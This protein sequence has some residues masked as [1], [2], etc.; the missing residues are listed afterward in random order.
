MNSAKLSRRMRRLALVAGVTLAAMALSSCVTIPTGGPVITGREVSEQELGPGSEVIP[1]GPVAGADQET[2][3]SGFI[4]AHSGSGN[5][6]A[7]R[8]FLSNP[9]AEEWE[10]RESVLIRTGNTDIERLGETAMAYNIV[11]SAIVDRD[12]LYTS[13]P[14]APQTLAYEFVQEAGEWRISAAPDGIVLSSGTF[15]KLF[16]GHTLYFLDPARQFLVPDLRWFPGG[17]AATRVVTALLNGPPAWLEGAVGTAFPDGTQLS[18]PR[19]VA[20]EDDV[21]MVDLTEEALAAN[22]GQRQLMR[23]QLEASLGKVPSISSVELSVGGTPL[24][25]TP[26]GRTGPQ[27][28]PQVDSRML[29]LR[30]GEFGYLAN[31]RITA[32][33]GLSEK[34]IATNPTEVTLD[35]SGTVAATLGAGGASLVRA[36]ADEPTL[37]DSRPGLI[38]PTLDGYGYIWTV[39]RSAP[40]SILVTDREGK[41]SAVQTTLPSDAEIVSL[42]VSRDGARIAALL[43]TNAGTRL[44]VA[45]II[46]DQN[47]GF[48]PISLGSEPRVDLIVDGG[49]AIDA[50]WVDELSVAVLS[51]ISGAAEVTSFEVGGKRTDLGNPGAAVAIVGG[52]GENGLRVLGADGVVSVRRGSGWQSGTAVSLISTQR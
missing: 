30:D 44:V 43:A 22:E 23:V 3:L 46:R 36:D 33:D 49:T 42:E 38:A 47:Q 15:S 19:R 4:A 12:G 31:N 7:A 8:Q 50:T 27:L 51:R 5:Y 41:Q 17:T 52:N 35:S 18:S 29:V 11:V 45:S 40:G 10:P 6:D 48:V 21:A 39:Q 16:S 28:R 25:I 26:L 13:Y 37:I 2:I 1:E 24:S 32:I 9:L 20:V 14:A 34:I